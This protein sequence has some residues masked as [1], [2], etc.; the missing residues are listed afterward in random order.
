MIPIH[1]QLGTWDAFTQLASDER[2]QVRQLLTVLQ[3]TPVPE[4]A[5]KD[6]HIPD[7]FKVVL[8]TITVYY[9]L[10]Y[11]DAGPEIDISVIRHRNPRRD[12]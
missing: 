6:A 4:N 2:A 7:T 11:T 3:E 1:F 5:V 12:D 8:A 10:V 9:R